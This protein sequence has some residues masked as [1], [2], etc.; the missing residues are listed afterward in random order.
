MAQVTI[1]I[2]N[3]LESKI[4][5]K[6]LSLNISISKFIAK[7]LEQKIDNEWN[8]DVKELAGSWKDFPELKEIEK[9]E[10]F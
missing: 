1:Y 3:E 5:N 8:A 6:A 9:R 10:E 4:K 7:I 2:N